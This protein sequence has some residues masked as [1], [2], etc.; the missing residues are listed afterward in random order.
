AAW[1][2]FSSL[3]FYPVTAASGQYVLG[4]PLW[5]KATIKLSSGQSL[6]VLATPNAP[7]QMFVNAITY[8]DEPVSTTFIKHQQLLSGGTLSF[9]LGIVPHPHR[10]TADQ[11]PYSLTKP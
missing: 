9:E 6:T 4:I 7:Q 10:Y 5:D 11:L 2:I 1:Y 8:N 3:G